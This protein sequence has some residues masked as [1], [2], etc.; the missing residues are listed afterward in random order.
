MKLTVTLKEATSSIKF[1]FVEVE[2]PNGWSDEQIKDYL[3][4]QA[5]ELA[6]DVVH[7]KTRAMTIRHM[8]LTGG[9]RSEEQR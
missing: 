8:R 7:G 4:D 1:G 5:D 3:N 9:K 2:V 6:A